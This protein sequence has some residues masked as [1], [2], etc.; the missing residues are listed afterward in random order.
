[1]TYPSLTPTLTAPST[2]NPYPIHI[3]LQIPHYRP[4]PTANQP[5]S[6]HSPHQ[7]PTL[8]VSFNSS[9]V[10]YNCNRTRSVHSVTYSSHHP[11][12]QS[13]VLASSL[14]Q[15]VSPPPS[16]KLVACSQRLPTSTWTPS[17]GSSSSITI[18]PTALRSSLPEAPPTLVHSKN[19]S[20][21]LKRNIFICF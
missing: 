21:K 4:D 8:A 16:Q 7:T 20:R 18:H 2:R 1:M 10:M 3:L 15:L 13:S 9:F 6:F 19:S 17:L 14:Y 5:Y 11:R 12:T